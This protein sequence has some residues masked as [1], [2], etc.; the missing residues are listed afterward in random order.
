M[1]YQS[2][3]TALDPFRVYTLSIS[4]P[5]LIT[6]VRL[7]QETPSGP[8]SACSLVAPLVPLEPLV[9]TAADFPFVS[10]FGELPFAAGVCDS[11]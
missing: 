3:P 2:D 7:A 8:A 9:R 5:S 6:R 11:G 1:I 4:A 10:A